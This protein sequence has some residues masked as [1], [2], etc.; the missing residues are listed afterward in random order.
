[1]E[2]DP[3]P[4]K[5]EEKKKIDSHTTPKTSGGG[6]GGG[7]RFFGTEGEKAAGKALT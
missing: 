1:M 6:V 2:V 4:T 3:D 5:I 7:L